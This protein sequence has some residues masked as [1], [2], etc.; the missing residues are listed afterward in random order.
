MD[1]VELEVGIETML[2]A[3][4]APFKKVVVMKDISVQFLIED[5]GVMV[6]GINRVDYAEINEKVN[7]EYPGWRLVY[8][9]TNDDLVEVRYEVIW[10]LMQSG[11]MKWIRINFP[12]EFKNLVIE[13]GFGNRIIDERLKRWGDLPKHRFFIQDNISAKNTATNY[14]LTTEPSFFDYMP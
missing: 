11:Y 5:F 1:M 8:I 6:C 9:T 2:R 12:R 7:T 13:S 10:T 4:H 3:L 14:V